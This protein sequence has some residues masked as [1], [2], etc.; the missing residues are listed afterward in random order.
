[1]AIGRDIK[2]ALERTGEAVDDAARNTGRAIKHGAE[3]I[4]DRM[5]D[6]D[7]N[8]PEP[9]DTGRSRTDEPRWR[10]EDDEPIADDGSGV[11]AGLRP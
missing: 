1:M 6:P 2:R 4:Q 11:P 9:T 3:D 7:L 8:R 5:D 10:P